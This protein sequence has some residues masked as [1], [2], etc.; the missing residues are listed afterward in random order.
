MGLAGPSSDGKAASHGGDTGENGSGGDEGGVC[1]APSSCTTVEAAPGQFCFCR[2][3][4]LVNM[5]EDEGAGLQLGAAT[6]AVEN[7]GGVGA[8]AATAQRLEAARAATWA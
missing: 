4:A 5:G 1:S 6:A 8:A 2:F 3:L 7:V